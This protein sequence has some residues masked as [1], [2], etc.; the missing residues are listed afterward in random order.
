[1][2]RRIEQAEVSVWNDPSG[3]ARHQRHFPNV[4]RPAVSISLL[5]SHRMSSGSAVAAWL[6]LGRSSHQ[7]GAD[8]MAADH[9]FRTTAA[10][11]Q[12]DL[13][14]PLIA[15]AAA[16]SAL[17]LRP[18][19]PSKEKPD[20][21]PEHDRGVWAWVQAATRLRQRC[22]RW[23]RNLGGSRAFHRARR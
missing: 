21:R 14:W 8:S 7:R 4:A 22:L 9:R 19:E 13:P 12:V 20:P 6:V 1:M 11:V 15:D 3:L 5:L 23:D 17:P 10:T 16:E 2:D 18:S